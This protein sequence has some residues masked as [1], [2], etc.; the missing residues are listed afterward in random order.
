LRDAV[1]F[2]VLSRALVAVC[3]EMSIAILR[4]AYSSIVREG[5]DCS[6]ALLNSRGEVLAQAARIPIQMNSLSLAMEWFRDR[7]R[8]DGIQR[9]EILITNDPYCNGQHLNDIMI[10]APV[11]AAS[12]IVA[13]TGSVI[14]AVDLGGPAAA[15]NTTAIDVYGE[16]LRI[17]GLRLHMRDIEGGWFEELL[18]GNSRTPDDLMGD[19]HAQLAAN[20]L[21]AK[22]YIELITKYGLD[23]LAE[24]SGDLMAYSE[25]LVRNQIAQLEDGDYYGEDSFDTDGLTDT[26]RNIAV[27][28]RVRGTEIIADFAGTDPQTPGPGNSPLAAT[29]SGVY[30]FVAAYLLGDSTYVNQGCFVPVKALVPYGSLLNP[31]PPAPVLAR[32]NAANRAYSALKRAF[33]CVRPDSVLAG[34]QDCPCTFSLSHLGD[35]GYRV[36]T[37]TTMGGWG[38]APDFDGQDGLSSQMSNATNLPVEYEEA[39]FDFVRVLNFELIPDS[40]GHGRYRGGM[41]QRRTYL[42][43]KDNVY[44]GAYTDRF[45]VPAWGLFGGEAGRTGAF[46]IIRTSGESI[47]LQPLASNV[48]LHAGDVLVMDM[49]GGGGYG[50]P[51]LRDPALTARDIAEGRVT[52]QS[53]TAFGRLLP[54]T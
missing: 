44:F 39:T 18:R 43:L 25:R 45:R 47:S 12:D 53:E 34:G 6:T 7:G 52:E 13:Y 9:D 33:A 8:L 27:T 2:S 41:A 28:L 26:P 42:M 11:Y 40:G 37:G 5:R 49:A 31:K 14:H 46:T 17:P 19:L 10:F 54:N 20:R 3:E 22:R 23:L 1:A 32:T 35:G 29:H 21:G 15:I 36:L 38:A 50:D 16:G 4:S 48:L 51:A 30:S 24:V